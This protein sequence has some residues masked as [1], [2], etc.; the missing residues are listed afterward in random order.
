MNSACLYIAIMYNSMYYVLEGFALIC[1]Y[2]IK[3]YVARVL[4]G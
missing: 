3:F 4:H 2:D 1:I